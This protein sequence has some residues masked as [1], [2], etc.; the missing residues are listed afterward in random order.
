MGVLPSTISNTFP[1]LNMNI[2]S[3]FHPHVVNRNPKVVLSS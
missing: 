3:G 1:Q 2:K